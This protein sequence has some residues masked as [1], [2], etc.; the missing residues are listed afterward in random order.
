MGNRKN[1]V[2]PGGLTIDSSTLYVDD[3][4]N[5]VG[6]G[7]TDP[8]HEL[9]VTGVVRASN[10]VVT[11]TTA[12]T[13]SAS[14]PDGAI[15]IDTTNAK[16][17]FRS[18]STWT[19]VSGGGGGL[20]V[21]ETE[22]AGASEGDLWFLETTGQTFV[23]YD[24]EWMEIGPPV[25]DSVLQR[26][27]AK[28]DIIVATSGNTASSFGVG[29]D[30]YFLVADS[31]EATGL[32]WKDL[33]ETSA[34]LKTAVD[35]KGDLLVG[36]ASDTVGRLAVGSDGQALTAS[37]GAATGLAWANVGNVTLTGVE[38]LTNKTLTS[39][40]LNTAILVSPEERWTVSATVANG[41]VNVDAL[42]TSAWLYTSNSS[43]NWTFNFRG[44]SG[45][46]LNSILNTGDSITVAFGVTNGAT[47][48]R[49][50]AFQI[51]GSSV[52]PQWQGGSAPSAGNADSVDMYVFTI[53]KTAATPTYRVFA[54]FTR[55]A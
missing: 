17:F 30:G 2:V 44:N 48:Y 33:G 11:L 23:F 28:G 54:S 5:R 34:L 49:A 45:T 18:S 38:T 26:I 6:I 10:G 16:L 39:P 25:I 7:K 52:T 42:T 29:T 51:D 37:S 1:F 55:F 43:A 4:N 27:S 41:T 8:D 19:E 35:A 36:T 46:T 12:G 3:P 9:D 14:L 13:P 31:S 22:P 21:S 20:T 50:T 40:V 32:N 24:S 15:A 47:P 53:V